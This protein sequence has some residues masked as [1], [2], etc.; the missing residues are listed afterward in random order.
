[1]AEKYKQGSFQKDYIEKCYKI[2]E[3]LSNKQIGALEESVQNIFGFRFSENPKIIDELLE[4]AIPLK[5]N[6]GDGLKVRAHRAL[7]HY[8]GR[9][10]RVYPTNGD[11]LEFYKRCLDPREYCKIKERNFGKISLL[12]IGGYLKEKRLI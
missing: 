1:M 4:E 10:G 7:T 8:A 2:G 5:K 12:D 3:Q 11:A 6:S 9:K